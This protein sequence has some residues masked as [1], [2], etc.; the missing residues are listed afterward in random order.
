LPK[1]QQKQIAKAIDMLE[2][3]PTTGDVKA[4]QGSQWKGWYRKRAGRYRIIFSLNH[5][6][7]IV[8]VSAILLRSEK[9]YK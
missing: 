9:T 3:D 2:T 1:K 7:R 5:A 8:N 6:E 4:L